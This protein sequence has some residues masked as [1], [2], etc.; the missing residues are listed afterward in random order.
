MMQKDDLAYLKTRL[1]GAII[2]EIIDPKEF[3]REEILKSY[4]QLILF[5]A[6]RYKRNTVDYE[7]LVVEGV[8]G[9][10]DAIERFDISKANDNPRAFHNLAIVR[11]KS[12]MFEYFLQNSNICSVP[13]YIARG[14]NLLEQLRNIVNSQEFPK[15]TESL[16][17]VYECPELE[18]GLSTESKKKLQKVKGKIQN[19]AV[20]CDRTYEEMVNLICKVEYDLNHIS[21][22]EEEMYE[23]SPEEEAGDQ[24]FMNKFL[25]NL[26]PS[27]RKVIT[28]LLEGKTLEETG[29]EI[30]LTKERARQIKESTLEYLHKTPLYRQSVK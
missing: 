17:H 11:I 5:L 4:F 7:D 22:G 3:D 19:L 16:I 29:K 24:E 1:K 27:A 12:Y 30:G 20:N 10:L 25:N 6:A 28:K 26:N 15:E 21:L 8:M 2:P 14:L 9:L 23:M 13:T 18:E